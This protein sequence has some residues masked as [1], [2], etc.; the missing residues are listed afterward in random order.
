[1]EET[2]SGD[3][4]M[5]TTVDNSSGNTAVTILFVLVIAIIAVAAVYLMQDHRSAS[6][7]IGDAVQA[8]PQGPSKA[9]NK[10][11]DQPPAQN[12]K[13]NI[14]NATKKTG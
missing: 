8:L 1:V 14:G 5:A 11:G 13:D 10:L 6:Q 3:T 2:P 9:V 7:R 4:I 12:L